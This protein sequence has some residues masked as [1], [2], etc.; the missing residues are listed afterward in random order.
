MAERKFENWV[1][2]FEEYTENLSSPFIYRR[3]VAISI[4]AAAAE[5]KI[6][7][8]NAMGDLFL[9]QYIFLL[10]APGVGKTAVTSL[11]YKAISSLRDHKVASSSITRATM[12][13][14]LDDAK[15]FKSTPT[16]T[17][18]FNALYIVS[19]EIG[20]LLP[21][22][23]TDFM[24]KLTDIY[25]GK[26]YSESR[27]AKAHCA[28]I[29]K[30]IYNLLAAGTPGYL[31][32]V[33][34]DVAWDQGFMSRV[35]IV[36][37]DELIRKSLFF[38]PE[39][40]TQRW[41]ELMKDL[42]G[43]ASL[44]GLVKFTPE[45]FEFLDTFWLGGAKETN[46]LHPK[47]Q[48]YNVRRPA[49]LL[50]LAMIASLAESNSLL[51]EMRHC[52][53]ALQWLTGAEVFI[54][55]MFKAMNSGGDTKIIKDAWYYVYEH[56]KIKQAGVPESQLYAFL[57]QRVTVEKIKWIV[58]VMQSSKLLRIEITAAGKLYFAN[59]SPTT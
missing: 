57:S 30:P 21:A 18:A 26:P 8:T 1:E 32:T 2:A 25:D 38:T 48:F 14:E 55:E 37:S 44:A 17:L 31:S 36:Y 52:Q 54:P 11:A 16:G 19:N 15:R 27:R 40:D 5:R 22:W 53:Q 45:A 47:L 59:G 13:S 41:E 9:N 43:I 4:L 33:I 20:V 35:I 42:R 3:W 49:H 34:P 58:E 39:L 50:K 12:I 6:W 29:P 56:N 10:G 23:E 51:V 28:D 7:T 24:N 46:L